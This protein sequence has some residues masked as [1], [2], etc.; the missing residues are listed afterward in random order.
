[1]V[2]NRNKVVKKL[3]ELGSEFP[4]IGIIGPRQIGKTTI[5]KEL[6]K[7]LNKET[8]YFDLERPSDIDRLADAEFT[9]SQ[10]ADKCV[11]IDEIQVK[12]DLF[13]LLRALVDEKRKP[14]RFIILGSAAPFLIR[15]TSES[16]AG[17]I[18]Y[19]ELGGF[20]ITETKQIVDLNTHLFRGGFPLSLLAKTDKASQNWLDN[21]IQT[22]TE[23]DLPQLG[24]P[25][26]PIVIRRLLEMIAWQHGNLLNSNSLGKSLGV[27]YHTLN[28]YLDFLEGAFLITR[29][30]PFHYNIKKR[31]VK[32]PKI[33]LNDVGVMHRLLRLQSY[34]QLLGSPFAGAS[35]EGFVID[36][37]KHWKPSDIDLY[38]Y[39]A[40]TG[41]E[42]DLVLVKGLQPIA[43]VEI[44]F[45]SS[46]SLTK[47]FLNS[48]ETLG[49]QSNFVILPQADNY[50]IKENIEVCDL[51]Y[52]LE[53]KLNNL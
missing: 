2:I 3:T 15:D 4:V 16:L 6:G 20:N 37:I 36:Q 49:T 35:W 1:M 9:L 28:K 44:K 51:E 19:I 48:T 22:Y 14:L 34:D 50:K 17:R 7:L 47:G 10:Y 32:S 52:F 27:S 38:F 21:F 18:A 12:P 24:L 41:A 25:A 43:T 45:S 29:L 30:Q 5:S 39:R 23:R 53:E 42:V 31:L 11:I 26:S 46:A 40:H 13:P 8:I 33:Y